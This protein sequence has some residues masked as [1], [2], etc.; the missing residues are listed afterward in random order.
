M[1][2]FGGVLILLG[3]AAAGCDGGYTLQKLGASAA[4]LQ[5]DSYECERDTRAAAIS[6]GGGFV[7]QAN[8][9]SFYERCLQARGYVA[10]P[11]TTRVGSRTGIMP[12]SIVPTPM[13][14]ASGRE[15]KDDERV[16]CQMSSTNSPVDFP[17]KTCAQGGGSI[18]GPA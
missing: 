6:F 11:V 4:D 1:K 13:R 5:R 8:A 3:V 2:G 12:S 17:A 14:D 10:V 16:M 7:G 18:V 9:Q 15:Y